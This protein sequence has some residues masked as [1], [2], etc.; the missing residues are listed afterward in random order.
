MG[1]NKKPSDSASEPK[2]QHSEHA[3]SEV[4]AP[5]QANEPIPSPSPSQLNHAQSVPK[6]MMSTSMQSEPMNNHNN[7]NY[8]DPYEHKQ[9]ESMDSSY[10]VQSMPSY[11]NNNN[12]N[13]RNTQP[14][15]TAYSQFNASKSL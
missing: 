10:S 1:M 3:K 14:P 13:Y 8:D 7:G 11:N 9:N 12:F 4:I 2:K 5:M 6:N 15:P